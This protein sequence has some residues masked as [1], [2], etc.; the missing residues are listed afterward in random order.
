MDVKN[1][2]RE[3]PAMH[4]HAGGTNPGGWH[5]DQ[6]YLFLHITSARVL[7]CADTSEA[8]LAVVAITYVVW[9]RVICYL[10]RPFHHRYLMLRRYYAQNHPTVLRSQ[11]QPS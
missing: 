10:R 1:H 4:H 7:L 3:S 11:L 6:C 5:F 8:P 9:F 2:G